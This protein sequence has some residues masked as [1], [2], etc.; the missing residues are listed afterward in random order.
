MM[1]KVRIIARE[2]INHTQFRYLSNGW[3]I[4]TSQCSQD[5]QGLQRYAIWI[6]DAEAWGDWRMAGGARTLKAA[7]AEVDRLSENSALDLGSG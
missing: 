4:T 6:P 3:R 2:R 7:M 5:R 1:P